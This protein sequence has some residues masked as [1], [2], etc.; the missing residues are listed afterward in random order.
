MPS[1]PRQGR[2]V[3]VELPDPRGQNPKTRPAVILTPTDE[4]RG[5]GLVQVAAITT[6]VGAPPAVAVPLPWH[7]DGHPRTKLRRPCEVVCD[8]IA[9]V[10]VTALQ[11][12]DGLV[13]L[14]Q[15]NEILAKRPR[16]DP[17]PPPTP[18]GDSQPPPATE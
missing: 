18:T 5:D 1:P 10:P 12:T 7:R 14:R 16:A 6:L 3:W 8:W 13:P 17:E 15:M 4:I 2:I 9:E 11:V